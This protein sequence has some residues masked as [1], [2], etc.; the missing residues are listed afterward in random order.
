ML[1]PMLTIDR[2]GKDF[3][4]IRAVAGVNLRVA[5]NE[6]LGLIGPNGSGKSTMVNLITGVFPPTGGRITFREE[7]ITGWLP[8]QVLAAGIGRTFQNI[9]LFRG[10]TVWQNLWVAQGARAAGRGLFRR[11][12]GI[13]RER[14]TQIEA[15]LDFC[16]LGNKRD[17]LAGSL[18]FGEQRR[19]ELARI[20]AADPELLLLDEPAAGMNVAEVGELRERIL[21]L[22]GRGKTV[23]LIEHHME[24]VMTVA[25]RVAVLNFGEKICEGSPA[26]VQDDARV[27]E[28][29]LG[30]RRER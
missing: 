11:W 20:L 23:V 30:V 18:A 10:L 16:G 14:L 24:L 28:A 5:A 29:Y 27:R 21:A 13:D 9:R 4:G 17:E 1:T 3:G 7:D 15:T 26:Q 25:D 6:I 2:L 12:L 19:L 22:R 8:H